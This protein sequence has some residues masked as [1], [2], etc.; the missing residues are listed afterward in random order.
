MVRATEHRLV[1][2]AIN[3]AKSILEEM[4]SSGKL[5]VGIESLEF[6]LEDDQTGDPAV[7]VTVVLPDDTTDENW[8]TEK[9]QPII[10]T[11]QGQIAEKEVDRIVYV[12]FTTPKILDAPLDD[13]EVA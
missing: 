9:F 10:E 7:T 6:T 4:K 12:L 13:E 1:Q 5:A 3:D 2:D 11:I 8:T